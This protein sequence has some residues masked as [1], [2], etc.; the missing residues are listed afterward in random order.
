MRSRLLLVP[1]LILG[2]AYL[3][4]GAIASAAET[5]EQVDLL[6]RGGTVV[7]MDGKGTV[8][9]AWRGGGARRSNCRRWDRC[10]SGERSIRPSEPST[11]RAR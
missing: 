1:I 5:P 11:P 2:L 9:G 10:R 8:S 3:F 7:P 6:I 4:G